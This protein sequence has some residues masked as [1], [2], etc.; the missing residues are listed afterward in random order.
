MYPSRTRTYKRSRRKSSG[1]PREIES[2]SV[3][4]K[5]LRRQ[6]KAR[7][8]FR[9]FQEILLISRSRLFEGREDSKY[10]ANWPLDTLDCIEFYRKS[11]Q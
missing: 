2:S 11:E 7:N 9:L 8:K 10:K 4:T 1:D 3:P 5:E 6:E